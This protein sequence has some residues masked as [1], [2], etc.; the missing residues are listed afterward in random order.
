M[1]TTQATQEHPSTPEAQQEAEVQAPAEALKA[2]VNTHAQCGVPSVWDPKVQPTTLSNVQSTKRQQRKDRGYLTCSYAATAPV[3]VI[4]VSAAPL[5][6]SVGRTQASD[7]THGSARP[8]G[9]LRINN[10]NNLRINNINSLRTNSISSLRVKIINILRTNIINSHIISNTSNR[11]SSNIR[12]ANH[13][14]HSG[15]FNKV[16]TPIACTPVNP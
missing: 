7:I 8:N 4:K 13:D 2:V 16:A 12:E 6:K 1:H 10:I 14:H 5:S 3:L 15:H 11:S 9:T